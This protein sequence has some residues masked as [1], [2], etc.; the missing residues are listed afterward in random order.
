ML[1]LPPVTQ[2]PTRRGPIPWI[3]DSAEHP[4][5]DDSSMSLSLGVTGNKKRKRSKRKKKEL[6]ATQRGTGN[7][8]P[9]LISFTGS[10]GSEASDTTA[11]D[12]GL[13]LASPV[14][15]RTGHKKARLSSHTAGSNT[16]RT[17]PLSPDAQRQLD[18]EVPGRNDSQMDDDNPLSGAS[19]HP[20]SNADAEI[21]H[22]SS[23]AES[24]DENDGGDG[25]GKDVPRDA[26]LT[27]KP[28]P[29]AD[30]ETAMPS[31]SSNPATGTTAVP[32]P[33]EATTPGAPSGNPGGTS[34]GTPG[35]SSAPD[36]SAAL[37]YA[38]E[39]RVLPSPALAVV[40][41]QIGPGFALDGGE[42]DKTLQE[43]YRDVM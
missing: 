28:A 36:P 16:S 21:K 10:S 42:E 6:R 7:D 11:A 37:S 4:R 39:A 2:W 32:S 17:S 29:P 14:P 35:D 38:M 27:F 40:M 19:D 18:A 9:E 24:S 1:G 22:K 33:T 25:S 41:A 12:S 8:E 31:T 15:G 34:G 5:P 26:E 13:N 30:Q 23:V 43:E 3:L 20:I